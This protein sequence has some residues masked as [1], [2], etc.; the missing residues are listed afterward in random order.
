VIA[1]PNLDCGLRRGDWRGNRRSLQDTPE[2]KAW[3]EGPRENLVIKQMATAMTDPHNQPPPPVIDSAR[4]LAY[5]VVDDIE[6]KKWGT[7]YSGDT[8]IEKVIGSNLGKDIGPMLFHC[9][10]EWNVLGVSGGATVTA[11]KDRAERN[12]PGVGSRWIDANVGIEEALAYYDEATEG[13]TCS[14][15]GKRPFE[16]AGMVSSPNAGAAICRECVE[17]LY[18]V[19]QEPDG[20]DQST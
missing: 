18:R 7:L 13:E 5:A 10:E 20:E 17:D 4:V 14:F 1:P 3:S 6:Y 9:D 16:V 19:F 8:L 2:P 12:Y 11:V 15:C